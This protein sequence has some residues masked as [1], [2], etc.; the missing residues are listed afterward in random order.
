MRLVKGEGNMFERSR[1]G[2]TVASR[3]DFAVEGGGASLGPLEGE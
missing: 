3:I 2:V 1:G